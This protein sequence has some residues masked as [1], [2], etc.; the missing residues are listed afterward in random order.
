MTA[1]F[2][3]W[4]R[5]E[6]TLEDIYQ[7]APSAFAAEPHHSRSERY[8][9]VSTREVIEALYREG[10][11]AFQASQATTRLPGKEGFTKHL[12]RMRHPDMP[13][14]DG[15]FPEVALI[16]SH[17]G[18]SAYKLK[19]GLWRL[20]CLNGCIT[21]QD[22]AGISVYHKGNLQQEVVEGA[23]SVV[24]QAPQLMHTISDMQDIHLD[25]REAEILAG[26]AAM[27]QY[28]E[29][30]PIEAWQL[31]EARRDEDRGESLW[32]R[33]NVIQENIT[34]GGRPYRNTATGRRN[35]TRAIRGIDGDLKLNAALWDM[36]RQM[37]QIKNGTFDT[38][39]TELL[40]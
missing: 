34:K 36:T 2:N 20:V 14:I 38:A 29:D 1:H 39:G 21:G 40:A 5:R 13:S 9:Y 15:L 16:N 25:Q 8:L 23:F 17:D 26:Q 33:Y 31:L 19:L 35:T 28:G 27:Y 11:R 22:F 6:L 7:R 10:F 18:S 12:I 37:M 4:D 30:T 24:S 3:H 32:S